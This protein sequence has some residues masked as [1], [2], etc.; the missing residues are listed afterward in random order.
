VL[1]TGGRLVVFVKGTDNAIHYRG[2]TSRNGSWSNWAS[3]GGT[4]T[5]APAGALNAAGGLAVFARGADNAMWHRW[6]DR[7]DGG[8]SDWVSLTGGF[9]S[10]P[11]AVLQTRGRLVVFGRGTDDRFWHRW[12]RS[13]DGEWSDWDVAAQGGVLTSDPACA[14][15]STGGLVVF[16]RGTDNAIWSCSQDR[17]DGGWSGWK[18]LGGVLTSG[19]AAVS[20][21]GLVSVLAR[22]TDNQI[23]L[24]TQIS[25]PPWWGPWTAFGVALPQSDLDVVENGIGELAVFA[26]TNGNALKLYER[27]GHPDPEPQPELTTVP[28]LIGL[29]SSQ[30]DPLITAARLRYGQVINLTGEIRSDRLRVIGQDPAA[31][32]R[33]PVDTRVSYRVELAQQQQGIKTIV[34]TN[35]HQQGRA[36]EV[37][38]WDSGAGG[39]ASKGNL[40]MGATVTLPLAAGR[41][42]TLAAVDRGLVNCTDGRPD[43][44]SCQRLLWGA[45]GDGAGIQ[46]ALTVT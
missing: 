19:P 33:V 6:Q 43:N 18:S 34:V 9:T 22:G 41:T 28:Q 20:Q 32:T 12:Q 15:N 16:A 25:E 38:L 11:S 23:W 39:W 29:L 13:R 14:L 27:G 42:Y 5:S 10:G 3:L 7:P 2:Q 45:R 40:G 21:S 36:V 30:V 26:L 46:V 4:L 44:V 24:R 35:A 31:G 8:W 1:Q 37:F 17:A